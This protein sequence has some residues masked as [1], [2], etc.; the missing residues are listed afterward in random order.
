MNWRHLFLGFDGRISRLPFWIGMAILLAVELVSYS[1]G[2]GRDNERLSAILELATLYP[3][4]AVLFKRAHDREMPEQVVMVYIVLAVIFAG[5]TVLD[6]DGTPEHPSI[7]YWLVGLPAMG[8][9]LFLLVDLG[10]RKGVSGA[11]RYGPDPL[12]RKT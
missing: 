7:L 2:F 5:L 10:L 12:Q 8:L 9:A 6:L 3:E 4:S 11:N 1:A